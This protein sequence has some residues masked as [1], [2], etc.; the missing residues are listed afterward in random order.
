MLCDSR[1]P[2]HD[3]VHLTGLFELT[4]VCATKSL[5]P[6]KRLQIRVDHI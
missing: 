3:N 4:I 6:D 2:V 5:T 1:F